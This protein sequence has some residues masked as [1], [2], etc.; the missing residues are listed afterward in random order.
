MST[1][2]NLGAVVV[3]TSFGVLTHAQALRAAGFESALREVE[4][5]GP[6]PMSVAALVC[7]RPQ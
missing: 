2:S 7:R 3:G 1:K 5:P 4:I 6:E